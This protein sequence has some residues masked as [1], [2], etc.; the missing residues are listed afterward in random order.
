M[1]RIETHIK[2]NCIELDNLYAFW[3]SHSKAPT[4]TTND[5]GASYR[6]IQQAKSLSPKPT[7]RRKTSPPQTPKGTGDKS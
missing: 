4:G 5:D 2:I 7:K 1:V 6:N 3:Q